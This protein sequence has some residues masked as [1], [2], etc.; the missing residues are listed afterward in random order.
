MILKNSWVQI[1]KILLLPE[2]RTGSLPPDTKK[3]PFEM[4]DKGFLM[5]DA[6]MGDVVKIITITGRI[7]EGTL[8]AVNPSY[9]HNYGTFIPEILE[10][11][12]MVKTSLFG[13]DDQ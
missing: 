9:M 6:K 11:D 1:H 3:V 10:I 13:G 2:E 8:I 12:K 5:N 7:I 4:W